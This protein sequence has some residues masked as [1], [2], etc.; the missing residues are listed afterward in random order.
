M[1]GR[2]I[3][4][5]GFGGGWPFWTGRPRLRC[6]VRAA[7]DDARVDPVAGELEVDRLRRRRERDPALVAEDAKVA[8][9]FAV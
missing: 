7:D 9:A 5:C 1:Q 6:R 3:V 4:G 8:W 2:G